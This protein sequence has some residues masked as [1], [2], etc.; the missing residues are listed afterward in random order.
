MYIL[1]PKIIRSIECT[2]SLHIS[3]WKEGTL[4]LSFPPPGLSVTCCDMNVINTSCFVM[5]KGTEREDHKNKK[6]LNG[7]QAVDNKHIRHGIF[8]SSS[9]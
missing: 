5:C 7:F 6:L 3:R 9:F 1:I 4:A 8:Q 2:L